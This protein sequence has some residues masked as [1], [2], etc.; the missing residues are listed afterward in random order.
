MPEDYN[1]QLRASHSIFYCVNGHDNV[2]YKKKDIEM[3]EG[4]LMNEYSKNA[5]LEKIIN[6]L[7]IKVK[8]LEHSFINWVLKPK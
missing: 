7:N 5:Q 6:Q 2:Y 4:L 3:A 8:K 1:K